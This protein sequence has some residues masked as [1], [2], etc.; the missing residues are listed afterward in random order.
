ML[1][2]TVGD[3]FLALNSSFAAVPINQVIGELLGQGRLRHELDQLT[4]LTNNPS[5]LFAQQVHLALHV[6]YLPL[7]LV[8]LLRHRDS[9]VD[10]IL[11]L[12]LDLLDLLFVKLFSRLLFLRL[13]LSDALSARF[14][15]QGSPRTLL[16]FQ[17]FC[18][19]SYAGCCTATTWAMR[20]L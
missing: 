19:C 16:I 18:D 8:L 14:I 15:A 10:V 20:H 6:V 12:L 17:D 1:N 4:L 5:H 3:K 9:I 11:F 13:K 7:R 2:L